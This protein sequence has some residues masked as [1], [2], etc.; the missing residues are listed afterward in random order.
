MK[1]E[2]KRCMAAAWKA[3]KR[4]VRSGKK[5]HW[6]GR[7]YRWSHSCEQQRCVFPCQLGSPKEENLTC[8]Q[9]QKE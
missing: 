6:P 2:F 4:I 8:V 9:K 5:M 1:E 3:L 7:G